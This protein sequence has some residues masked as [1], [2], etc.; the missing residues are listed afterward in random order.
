MG[1]DVGPKSLQMCLRNIW[2]VPKYHIDYD[3]ETTDADVALIELK[4]P[5]EFR[6]NAVPVCL[7]EETGGDFLGKMATVVGWGRLTEFGES[8]TN[9]QKVQVKI[10]KNNVC[11]FMYNPIEVTS[12]MLCAYDKKGGKDACQGDSGGSLSI[13]VS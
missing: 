11:E 13:K 2:M 7:P 1:L 12:N 10:I 3:K 5:I 4:E 8:S 6:S 9:L